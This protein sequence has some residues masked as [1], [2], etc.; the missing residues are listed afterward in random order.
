[1]PAVCPLPPIVLSGWAASAVSMEM[2][3]TVPGDIVDPIL[4]CPG[5][6]GVALCEIIAINL[7]CPGSP[8]GADRL[9]LTGLFAERL[10]ADRLILTGF[11]VVARLAAVIL[12]LSTS[13]FISEG[14]IVYWLSPTSRDQA[15]LH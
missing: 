4:P 15:F 8:G 3:V 9:L 2:G 7:P 6:M 13:R 12:R 1:M 11:S 5:G 10:V 14:I